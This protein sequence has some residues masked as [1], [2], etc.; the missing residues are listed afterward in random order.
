[1][2][3]LVVLVG[4]GS[5]VLGVVGYLMHPPIPV[6]ARSLSVAEAVALVQEGAHPRIYVTVDARPAREQPI[7]V[8]LAEHPRMILRPPAGPYPLPEPSRENLDELVSHLGTR[9]LHAGRMGPAHLAL[10]GVIDR[11]LQED[12]VASVRFLAPV[13]GTERLLWGLSP[14]FDD[15]GRGRGWVEKTSLDGV[16]TRMDDIEA[17]TETFALSFGVDE[18]RAVAKKEIG[19]EIPPGALVI[20]EG[21]DTTPASLFRLPVEGSDAVLLVTPFYE[22][23]PLPEWVD[24]GPIPGVLWTWEVDGPDY[25]HLAQ[26]LGVMPQ[27]RYGVIHHDETAEELNR[28]TTMGL[29]IFGGLGLA[30]IALGGLRIVLV[31]RRAAKRAA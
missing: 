9:V 31:R 24:T 15:P 6:E 21:D 23:E 2:R 5:L 1:M 22:G 16:L 12:E 26:L 8:G 18:I 20:I 7:Y 11:T 10:Q 17:N 29:K 4:L 3:Y 28:K 14:V 25:P 13:V 30:L 27:E 19:I